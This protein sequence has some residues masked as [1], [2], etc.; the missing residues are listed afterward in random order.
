M[1]YLTGHFYC[2][3]YFFFSV[4]ILTSCRL[5]S[6]VEKVPFWWMSSVSDHSMLFLRFGGVGAAALLQGF[7]G[8]PGDLPSPRNEACRR[9]NPRCQT[10]CKWRPSCVVQHAEQR[11]EVPCT[12]ISLFAGCDRSLPGWFGRSAGRPHSSPER[13]GWLAT[14]PCREDGHAWCWVPEEAREKGD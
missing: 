5:I 6:L 1:L 12:G 2:L 7:W 4:L 14:S 13:W 8:M 3:S 11:R 9:E 10:C